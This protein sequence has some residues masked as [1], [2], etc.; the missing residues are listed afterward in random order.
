MFSIRWVACKS[1]TFAI[2]SYWAKVAKQEFQLCCSKW[3]IQFR[4]VRSI[5]KKSLA[6]NSQKKSKLPG[7][8]ISTLSCSKIDYGLNG[9]FLQRHKTLDIDL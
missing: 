7:E 8:A 6:A 3:I 1:T 4:Y 9:V 2:E 5:K